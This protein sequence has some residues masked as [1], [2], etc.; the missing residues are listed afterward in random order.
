M[1]CSRSPWLPV[2]R[3]MILP[4]E[5]CRGGAQASGSQIRAQERPGTLKIGPLDRNAD[6]H[7]R[8]LAP[9]TQFLEQVRIGKDGGLAVYP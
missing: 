6:R 7:H 3:A 8:R 2:L 9:G 5:M 1:R 4:N